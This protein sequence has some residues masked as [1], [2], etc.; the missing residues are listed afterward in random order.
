M[1]QANVP[2]PVPIRVTHI[3]G[4]THLT[5]GQKI[6]A[7]YK[8]DDPEVYARIKSMRKL[9]VGVCETKNKEVEIYADST[10]K[11]WGISLALPG[12]YFLIKETG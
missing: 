3:E 4:P 1:L 11:I 8:A 7:H 5:A 10:G 9:G 12:R 2:V 6:F